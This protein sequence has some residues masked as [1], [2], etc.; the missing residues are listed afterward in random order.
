MCECRDGFTGWACDRLKCPHNADN[1]ECSGHGL[2]YTMREAAA[3]YDGYRFMSQPTTY[4]LWDADMAMG[5]VCDE[6]WQGYDC[7]ERECPTGDDPLTTGG[8]DEVQTFKCVCSNC[9]TGSFRF[10]FRGSYSPDLSFSATQSQLEAALEAMA[11]IDHVTLTWSTAGGTGGSSGAALCHASDNRTT[12][13]TFNSESGDLPLLVATADSTDITLTV[14][15]TQVGTKE[16]APCNNRGF[17]TSDALSEFGGTCNCVDLGVIAFNSSDGKGG[18]GNRGDC[19]VLAS[20]VTI[21]NCPLSSFTTTGTDFCSGHGT[22]NSSTKTCTCYAGWKGHNC[23]LRGCPMGRAWFDEPTSANTAHAVTECSAR[24]LCDARTGKCDCQ[25]GFEGSACDRMS[26]PFSGSL[27]CSGSGRCIS[28]RE[29]AAAGPTPRVYGAD[30]NTITVWDADKIYGCKCDG[31]SGDYTAFPTSMRDGVASG[32]GQDFVGFDCSQRLC[33]TGPK[34]N[35]TTVFESQTL[36]CTA[37]QGS[38]TVTYNGVATGSIAYNADAAAVEAAIEAHSN[39]GDVAITFSTGTSACT[40]NG[41][42]VITV[43]F[44]T[45]LGDITELTATPTGSGT[46]VSVATSVAGTKVPYECSAN[47]YCDRKTGICDCFEGFYSSDGDGKQGTRGDC[48]FKQNIH[49][50]GER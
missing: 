44:L 47:G 18:L 41:A 49:R 19:G 33:R 2:C 34:V 22:C 15:Q 13:I 25:K 16:N 43:Q 4:D 14:A 28:M 40:N 36:T 9:N 45:E 5:C 20:G 6:G 48:G 23:E 26:C 7:S 1:Q 17:C 35:C 8:L 31:W 30:P 38:F 21:A 3:E 27:E 29:M 11:T 37:T 32:D 12:A 42:N 46:S 10:K 50:S 39:V 24:G